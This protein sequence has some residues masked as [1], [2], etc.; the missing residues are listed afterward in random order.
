MPTQPSVSNAGDS[1]DDDFDMAA[2]KK[3]KKKKKKKE[4]GGETTPMSLAVTNMPSA[5]STSDLN[6]LFRGYGGTNARLDADKRVATL[7]FATKEQMER[8]IAD[9]PEIE[10]PDGTWRTVTISAVDA[11]AT[12]PTLPNKV[13]TT[14]DSAAQAHAAVDPAQPQMTDLQQRA[15]KAA[16]EIILRSFHAC[17]GV[18]RSGIAD[19]L[20][21]LSVELE[22]MIGHLPGDMRSLVFEQFV[23]QANWDPKQKRVIRMPLKLEGVQKCLAACLKILGADVPD[24][25]PPSE[26]IA[27]PEAP[28]FSPRGA[29]RGTKVT[30]TGDDRCCHNG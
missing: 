26:A 13:Q 23:N 30:A 21:R 18:H 19:F 22:K 5:T 15:V 16:T 27:R 29:N 9:A 7:D 3:K 28:R 25:L 4:D 20:D 8:V 24:P 1:A 6:S 10:W 11:K 12:A 2:M 14:T 17:A